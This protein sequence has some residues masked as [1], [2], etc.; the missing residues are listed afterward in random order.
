[1]DI[2]LPQINFVICATL[3]IPI[4]FPFFSSFLLFFFFSPCGCFPDINLSNPA[5]IGP[6]FQVDSPGL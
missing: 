2:P 1:M 4:S 3:V 5:K 6:E